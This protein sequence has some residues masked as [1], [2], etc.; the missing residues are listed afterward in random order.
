MLPSFLAMEINRFVYEM[1]YPFT[2]A[3]EEKRS[4]QEEDWREVPRIDKD[5]LM[6]K[7]VAKDSPIDD[8]RKSS[9]KNST[10]NLKQLSSKSKKSLLSEPRALKSLSLT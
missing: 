10:L 8:G 5:C 4:L 9:L 1:V 6:P 3:G 2:M 7:D